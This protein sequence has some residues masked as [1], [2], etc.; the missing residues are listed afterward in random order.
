MLPESPE[1]LYSFYRFDEC[2]EVLELINSWNKKEDRV[3]NYEFDVEV[4]LKTIR[5]K[6]AVADNQESF[7]NSIFKGEEHR[8]QIEV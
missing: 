6:S 1:Y 7:R 5:F 2:R 3:E 4:E 8:K